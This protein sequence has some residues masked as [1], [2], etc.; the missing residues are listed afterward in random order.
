MLIGYEIW[1]DRTDLPAGYA[2]VNQTAD[3]ELVDIE[4]VNCNIPN[5]NPELWVTTAWRLC[6][7][8]NLAGVVFH[9]EASTVSISEI[10]P[11]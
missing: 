2:T 7:L 6:S 8:H 5:S 10:A 11:F 3:G 9:H 4:I 1:D